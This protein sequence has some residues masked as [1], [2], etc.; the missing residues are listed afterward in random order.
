MYVCIYFY[1]EYAH[2]HHKQQDLVSLQLIQYY[3]KNDVL[4]EGRGEKINEIY[5]IHLF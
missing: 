2:R 1:L 3:Q 4:K 5:T